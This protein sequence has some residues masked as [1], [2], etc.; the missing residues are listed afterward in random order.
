[1]IAKTHTSRI[2]PSALI[3]LVAACAR[4]HTPAPAPSAAYDVIIEN[5][6]IVDGTG[7]GWFYGDVALRG[8]RIARIAPRGVLRGASARDRIDA[9]GLVVAPGFID[10]QGQSGGDFLF[11]DGRDI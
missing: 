10:I 9:S 7:A 11:G 6:R 2:A 5:G 1:M 4:A 8:D 3:C